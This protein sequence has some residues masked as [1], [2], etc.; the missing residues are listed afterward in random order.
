MLAVSVSNER[1]PVSIHSASFGTAGSPRRDEDRPIA[2]KLEIAATAGADAVSTRAFR[3]A[4]EQAADDRRADSGAQALAGRDRPHTTHT[5][6]LLCE[7]C[8]GPVD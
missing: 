1:G 4:A 8:R 2:A 5:L 7:R 6:R 3:A